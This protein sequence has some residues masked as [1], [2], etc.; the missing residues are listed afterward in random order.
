MGLLLG[1][2]F[3]IGLLLIIATFVAPGESRPPQDGRLISRSRELLASAGVEGVTPGAFIGACLITGLLGFALMFAVSGALPIGA[4]FGLMAG[5]APVALAKSRARRRL[6]EFRELW[7]DVVDN[8]ASAVRAG[9]S[10]SE[11]LAQVGE[12]G[13]LPL[14][15]PFRRFG[16]DYASTGRFAESLD[17]LK[18]RLAD[19]VGDRVIEALRIAR[20]VGGGDLGR[21]L[22]SLSTFLRDDAR[23]RSEL[24]SR[25]SWSVNGARV[26]VAAPWLVLAL[27]SF[28]GDV[29]ERYNSPVGAIII[30]AGAVVCVFA[31]RLMLRIGRLPEPERVLR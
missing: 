23:T 20:E 7:P 15:E 8:I 21:L 29:I 10:L 1:L 13:P 4:V 22:R 11:A 16:A 18:A 9:L 12:R 25:Q 30:G 28:Q 2:F 27:L 17:R 5:A 14:R 6:A 26:A 3:G 31:Y 19:P 24:E